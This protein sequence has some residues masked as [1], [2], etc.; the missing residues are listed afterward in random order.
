MV[1]MCQTGQKMNLAELILAILWVRAISNLDNLPKCMEV[2]P[3]FLWVFFFFLAEMSQ[4]LEQDGTTA[5]AETK[6]QGK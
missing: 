6:D 4:A 5:A 1:A 3:Y 2:Y